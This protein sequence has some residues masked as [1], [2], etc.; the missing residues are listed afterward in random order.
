MAEQ[1]KGFRSNAEAPGDYAPDKKGRGPR[2]GTGGRDSSSEYTEKLRHNPDLHAE[3]DEDPR[4]AEIKRLREQVATLESEMALLRAG[5]A[6]GIDEDDGED[7]NQEQNDEEASLLKQLENEDLTDEERAELE[8][9]LATVRQ[10]KAL[11]ALAAEEEELL[12]ILE[13]EE[14]ASEDR[15]A[16]EARLAEVQR[17]VKLAKL[18]AEEAEL[19]RLLLDEELPEEDRAAMEARLSAIG[20]ERGG[21]GDEKG[22]DT[23]AEYRG[24]LEAMS[25]AELRTLLRNNNVDCES[26]MTLDV[27]AAIQLAHG[28]LDALSVPELRALLKIQRGDD[29]SDIVERD[30]DRLLVEVAA[31]VGQDPDSFADLTA[32]EMMDLCDE[33]GVEFVDKYTILQRILGGADNGDA[34]EQGEEAEQPGTAMGLIDLYSLLENHLSVDMNEHFDRQVRV[35]P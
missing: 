12:A 18:D 24:T 19:R 7:S 17:L 25:V 30:R 27:A 29:L 2:F 16:A 21:E 4:D 26:A 22:T 23:A 3:P 28:Q 6:G 10:A 1:P 5:N 31:V 15:V 11:A 20:Q 35:C 13:D 14:L 8:S 34:K 9:Q 33:T 32:K